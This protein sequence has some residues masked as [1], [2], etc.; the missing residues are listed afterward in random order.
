MEIARSL[1]GKIDVLLIHDSPKLPLPEYRKMAEDERTRAIEEAIYEAK[2]KIVLCGHLHV[3]PYTAYRFEYGTL[4]VRVD[5]SQLS[6][7]YLIL[8][9]DNLAIEIWKD[10]DTVFPQSMM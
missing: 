5:S 10:I 4:Y 9:T 8:H 1:R 7:H 3:S 6:R 2:P